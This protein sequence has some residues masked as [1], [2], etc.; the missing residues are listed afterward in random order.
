MT[1]LYLDQVQ[2]NGLFC[3]PN[4]GQKPRLSE[5]RIEEIKDYARYE[6][7]LEPEEIL[8]VAEISNRDTRLR[9][10]AGLIVVKMEVPNSDRLGFAVYRGHEYLEE[11]TAAVQRLADAGYNVVPDEYENVGIEP[12]SQSHLVSIIEAELLSAIKEGDQALNDA[13]QAIVEVQASQ[14]DT[15]DERERNELAHRVVHLEQERLELVDKLGQLGKKLHS[16]TDG[17][18]RLVK[19]HE[20]RPL[21]LKAIDQSI[22]DLTL[23]SAWI[24]PEALDDEVCRKIS[25]AIARGVRVRIAWGLGTRRQGPENRRNIE[26]GNGALAKLTGRIPP[27]L[28]NLLV[29]KRTE[30]HEKFIICDNRFCAWG[31]LN[32]LFIS[33]RGWTK[34]NECLLGASRRNTAMAIQR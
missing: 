13:E 8:E 14:Q 2:K 3:I 24:G 18:F 4:S 22:T 32:W 25:D 20:H 33:R 12:W 23:V 6:D 34:R 7:G 19:A 16:Q 5:L 27:N 9:Y 11:H 29:I 26:R 21:L 15:Q 30:T 31:S 10:W 28:K 1:W 17:T